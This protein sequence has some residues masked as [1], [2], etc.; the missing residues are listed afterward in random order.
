MAV[1]GGEV[2]IGD[3]G[4]VEALRRDRHLVGGAVGIDELDRARARDETWPLT[5]TG[6]CRV[7]GS[8]NGTVTPI[9]SGRSARRSSRRRRAGAAA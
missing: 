7:I 6:E 9:A 2:A 1:H 8:V 3:L 4:D 5:L